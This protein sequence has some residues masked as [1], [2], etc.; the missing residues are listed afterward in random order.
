MQPTLNGLSPVDVIAG[1]PLGPARPMAVDTPGQPTD[2][3]S[4]L[5][6]ALVPALAAP[7]LAVSFSGGRDSSLLLAVA[8]SAARLHG[9]PPPVAITMRFPHAVGSQ[10]SDWQELV[11]RELGVADWEVLELNRELDYLGPIAS[12]GLE[13]DG[14]HFP[15]N[16]HSN[17]PVARALGRG[18]VIT[19]VGGDELLGAWRWRGRSAALRRSPDVSMNARALGSVVLGGAPGSLR[20]LVFRTRLLAQLRH[21]RDGYSWLTP[22]GRRAVLPG[23]VDAEDQPVRWGDY[24]HWIARRRRAVENLGSLRRLGLV[25]GV[26][27]RAPLFEPTV[28]AA[29][30]AA[31]GGQGWANRTEAMRD[32]VGDRL[33]DEVVT[34]R[35]KASFV[36]VFWGVQTRS[37]AESWDGTG[38]DDHLVDAAALQAEWCSEQPDF[39]S[40][41]LLQSAWLTGRRKAT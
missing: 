24:V 8:M 23:L 15:P 9:L 10:E 38:V 20:R 11:I 39:R 28:L 32:I 22:A 1:V 36:D 27:I 30:A 19:G 37:F 33:P 14:L 5:E 6:Q 35:S 31:R 26:D 18:T 2:P 3:W 12:L 40:T 25:E 4:A 7:P 41:L 16:G 21:G 13:R 34:R 29:L 17:V